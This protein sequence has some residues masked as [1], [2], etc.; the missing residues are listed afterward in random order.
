MF[1]TRRPPGFTLIELLVVIAIIAVLIA[2]L[3]PAVQSAREAARRAQ[4]V[5]NLKQMGLA[6]H[7][8]HDVNGVFPDARPGN[9]PNLNDSNAF[10]GWVSC[11]PMLEQQPLSNAWNF[12]VS[13]DSVNPPT[14]PGLT[15][16]M[17]PQAEAT[18]AATIL[19]VFNC[20]SDPHQ[21]YFNS[22]QYAA[23]R[24]DIPHLPQLAVSSYAFCAGTGGPPD[25]C[26][27]FSLPYNVGDLKHNNNGFGDYGRPHSIAEF[28]D[29]TSNTIAVGEAA[30]NND[31]YYLV[32]GQSDPMV[33]G[34]DGAFN[35]WSVALRHG[36]NFRE[37]KNPINTLPWQG[38]RAGWMNGAFGSRHPGGANFLFIDGHVV[39]LKNSLNLYIYRSLSTRAGGEVISADSF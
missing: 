24:N 19:N 7:N 15:N 5:N 27:D 31:G 16:V 4:C 28:T 37:T 22:V 3:L 36:S 23:W 35:V 33:T 2:L 29:G 17:F 9:Y 34:N 10:S 14:D 38:I 6:A 13:F 18:V 1:G 32:P 11:L 8:Y 30:Y 25:C 20:P 12:N 21:P 39:F 26:Y